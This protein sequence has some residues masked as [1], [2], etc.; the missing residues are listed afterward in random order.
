M[1]VCD[2]VMRRFLS[3]LNVFYFYL[4]ALP[5]HRG[6]RMTMDFV[7][8]IKLTFPYT[9]SH[10]G[11]GKN[12]EVV[13]LRRSELQRGTAR[14]VSPAAVLVWWRW[15]RRVWRWWI[16]LAF[17]TATSYTHYSRR[18]TLRH[19]RITNRLIATQWPFIT[20]VRLPIIYERKSSRAH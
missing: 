13:D 20:T 6:H 16:Q 9:Q 17:A 4:L 5:R 11:S 1:S 7:N 3:R 2:S 14:A 18:R 12:Y 8:H 19:N 15:R 10:S